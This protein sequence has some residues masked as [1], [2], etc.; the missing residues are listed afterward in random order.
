MRWPDLAGGGSASRTTRW[1]SAIDEATGRGVRAE[2][3]HAGGRCAA[4][5]QDSEKR[6]D[7]LN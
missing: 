2:L 3:V 1:L 5:Q 4:S 7:L 6:L